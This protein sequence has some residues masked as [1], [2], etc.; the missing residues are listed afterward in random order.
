VRLVKLLQEQIE[1]Y[2]LGIA[3]QS[4]DF[5]AVEPPSEVADAFDKVTSAAR[6]RE[7]AVNQA[8][9]F[10]NRTIAQ[11]QGDSEQLLNQ[12]RAYRDGTIQ[13]ARGE[14]Q[15]FASLLAEYERSPAL[16]S[17][18][19]YLETMAQI[20]PKFRSKLILDTDSQVDLSIMG[21]DAKEKKPAAK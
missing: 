8:Q 19:M 11:A 4:V 13:K 10:A 3:V 12:A 1:K 18:R 21:Q 17:T 20:L 7:Q 15:R 16:T 9:S 6:E 5:G 2:E 14:T